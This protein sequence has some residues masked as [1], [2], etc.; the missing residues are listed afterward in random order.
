MSCLDVGH[1]YRIQFEQ[2]NVWLGHVR[3]QTIARARGN[4]GRVVSARNVK[5]SKSTTGAVCAPN[6]ATGQ[7]IVSEFVT[8]FLSKFDVISAFSSSKD[9]MSSDIYN[10]VH[11]RRIQNPLAFF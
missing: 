3:F 9:V 7:V 10:V 8:H 2:V 6:S 1:Y 5:R 11:Q 4:G